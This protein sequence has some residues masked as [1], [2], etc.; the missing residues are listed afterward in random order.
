MKKVPPKSTAAH[1]IRNVI[2]PTLKSTTY[3]SGEFTIAHRVLTKS[4]SVHMDV[5]IIYR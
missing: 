3:K 1:N 4:D 5:G 2:N